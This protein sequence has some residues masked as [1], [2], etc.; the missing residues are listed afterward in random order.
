MKLLSI[1]LSILAILGGGNSQSLADTNTGLIASYPFS[2]NA[3]DCVG[4]NHGTAYHTTLVPDR[5]G[6]TN[7]AYDF[8]GTSSYIALEHFDLKTMEDLTFSVWVKPVDGGMI[9]Y[10]G[11]G[12]DV[13]FSVGADVAD[14]SV[15][16]EDGTWC[17]GEIAISLPTNR[18]FNLCGV[19]QKGNKVELWVD[20]SLVSSSNAPDLALFEPAYGHLHANLGVLQSPVNG[21][22]RS[23][24]FHGAIDEFR[25][26]NRAL[27]AADILELQDIPPSYDTNTAL[28]ASYTFSGN[29][30]DSVGT[31]HGTAYHTTLVPDRFGR[32]NGAYD[33][34][35][36]SS[37]IALEHFDLKTM[38]DVTFSAWVKP[39][40][41]GMIYYQGTGGDVWFSV[42]VDVA[43]FSVHLEDGTWCGGEIPISLPTN[44]FFNLCGV[45]QKG[46][47]VE[48]WVDGSLVSSCNAPDLSLFEPAYGHLHANLGVLQSPVNGFLRSSFFHGA[49]DELR[50]YNR[51]L[52]PEDIQRLQDV[53][54]AVALSQG[55]QLPATGFSVLVSGQPGSVYCLQATTSLSSGNWVNITTNTAPFTFLDTSATNTTHRFYRAVS[56]P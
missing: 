28:I 45:F 30:N 13:W 6:R 12:G 56:M 38:G 42:G 4:T 47:K 41:G 7:G 40:D 19:F 51:A 3:N 22:L 52:S 1:S 39:V 17:G 33:F 23:S 25:V 54:T 49:I 50:I 27:A 24:F 14:F 46:N 18:F 20:G 53:P 16:L 2:G 5:F 55:T 48:L 15:H 31:N 37:Y 32:P 34:N 44:R 29:A 26:Y 43:D 11:T 35:G 21:F 36:T 9:Y 8:N 10:Q